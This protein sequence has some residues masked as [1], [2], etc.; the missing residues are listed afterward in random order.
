MQRS[1]RLSLVCAHATLVVACT[2]PGPATDWQGGAAD[3][4]AGALTREAFCARGGVGRDGA[5]CPGDLAASHFGQGL[6]ACQGIRSAGPLQVIP[7]DS[8]G[9]ATPDAGATGPW[10]CD[11][12]DLV[13][14]AGLVAE[15]ATHNDNA[16]LGLS[17]DQLADV[18]QHVSLELPCGRYYLQGIAASAGVTLYARGRVA[19]FVDGDV[20]ASDDLHVLAAPGADLDV[21]V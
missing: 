11:C 10:T 9:G 2:G 1:L 7:F 15:A 6:C 18:R 5:T 12:T 8:R 21:F 14:V 4:Q 3:P 13:D 20:T 19:L 16:A 17:P